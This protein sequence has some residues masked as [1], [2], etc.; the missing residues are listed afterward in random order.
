VLL[1]ISLFKQHFSYKVK[2]LLSL[3]LFVYLN[4]TSA[5]YIISVHF[6]IPIRFINL[7]KTLSVYCKA[8]SQNS[9]L[10]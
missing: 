6:T 8:N 4:N 5:K 10:R 9:V 7:L 2:K 3:L 1:F